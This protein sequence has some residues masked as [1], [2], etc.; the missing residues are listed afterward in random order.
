MEKF[1]P[2]GKGTLKAV[3]NVNGS[4]LDSLKSKDPWDLPS[5]DDCLWFVISDHDLRAPRL[6]CVMCVHTTGMFVAKE[7]VVVS[8]KQIVEEFRVYPCSK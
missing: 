7:H 5:C 2:L 4:L 1:R 6:I 8:T 3:K